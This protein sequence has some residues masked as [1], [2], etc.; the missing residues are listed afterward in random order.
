M[1][2]PDRV[3]T[4]YGEYV[5]GDKYVPA[6]GSKYEVEIL[7]VKTYKTNEDIVIKGPNGTPHRIDWFKMSYRYMKKE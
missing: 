1:A 2:T 4:P 7:D 6:S 3:R 5:V